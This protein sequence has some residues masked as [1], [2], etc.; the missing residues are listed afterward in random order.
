VD[1]TSKPYK[2]LLLCD[3]ILKEQ[4]RRKT[5]K[6]C[7][8]LFPSFFIV[9]L[10]AQVSAVMVSQEGLGEQ[11]VLVIMAKFPDVE[12]GFSIEKMRE[13]YFHKL[14][15]Y[16]RSVSYEKAWIGG[17]MTHWYTLPR[18]VKYYRISEHNLSVEKDRIN[19]LI[20]DAINLA[21]KHEDFSKYSMVF[22]SLGA[23]RKDYGMMGLCGYPGML[24]WQSQLP[25]RTKEMG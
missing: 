5:V 17:K 16:L 6:K 21:D 10:A 9:I 14:N 18:K 23:K 24:G 3:K 25:L 20:Q 22:I 4:E 1:V 12:P 11:S 8:L 15:R 2:P 7:F 13:K 19:R